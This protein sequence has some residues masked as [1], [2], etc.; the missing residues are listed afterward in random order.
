MGHEAP[1]AAYLDKAL[2]YLETPVQPNANKLTSCRNRIT[3]D[4]KGKL[5][6]VHDLLEHGRREEAL[7]ELKSI[8]LRYG[9]LAAPDSLELLE[10]ISA[11]DEFR[12]AYRSA[13]THPAR[14]PR[15]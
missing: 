11:A 7:K 2:E 8:D 6:H 3:A 13:C 10:R 12:T 4:L 15:W 5:Q 14:N 1:S 9:G